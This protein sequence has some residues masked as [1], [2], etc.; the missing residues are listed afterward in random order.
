[1][2]KEIK[3]IFGIDL[4]TTYSSIAY[5]HKS[6]KPVVLPNEENSGVT[7][8]VVLF[9][10]DKILVG[11]AAK[12][13][14]WLHPEDVAAFVKRSMGEKDFLF[15]IGDRAYTAEEISSFI[16]RKLAMDAQRTL[17]EKVTD[18]VIT[19]PA[20]FGVNE[21]EATR[22]AGE[23]AGLRGRRIVNEP[24][25]A[26]LAYGSTKPGEKKKI[27]VYDLGGGTFDIT[28][29]DVQPDSIE[30]ICTGGDHNLGGKDWDDRVVA[31]LAEEYQRQTG[32]HDDI[33]DDPKV[34]QALQFV[35]ESAKKMLSKQESVRVP[36]KYAGV[37]ASVVLTRD[38]FDTLTADLLER[39][40]AMVHGTMS[41][42]RRKAVLD[43]DEFILVGGSTRMPQVP[44]RIFQEFKKR[45]MMFEPENA[46]AKGAAILGWKIAINDSLA[47]RVKEINIGKAQEDENYWEDMPEIEIEEA[48]RERGISAQTLKSSLFKVHDVASK[49]FGILL[50]ETGENDDVFNVILRNSRVPVRAKDTFNTAVA[51]QGQ[52]LIRVVECES[53]EEWVSYT[54][55]V[56]IGTAA[57]KLPPHLPA[58]TPIVIEFVLSKEGRLS[59]TATE[60]SGGRS[61]D[62]KIK[63]TAGI[64]DNALEEAKERGKTQ[65]IE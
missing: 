56:E 18:V 15:M 47:E 24:T 5:V 36:I 10:N 50:K 21:R 13:R 42:A 55:A 32:T 14:A 57:L 26:A 51:N 2:A 1:M 64:G 16:L 3:K 7:P 19:C 25:A 31:Y 23:I 65:V 28:M 34:W 8:S 62:V 46:V 38:I 40:I 9:E 30:V 44:K 11:N 37:A 61:V 20:Y 45:P 22:R 58:N 48:A 33:L 27:L 52:V 29:I 39:T 6:G 41:E 63:P 49:S 12:K 4:G 60:S 35:A 59:I 17:Q 53:S 54:S 43:F